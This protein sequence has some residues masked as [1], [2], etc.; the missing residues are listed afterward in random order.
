MAKL[1]ENM[2]E[3]ASEP[4]VFEGLPETG[5]K[6]GPYL[7]ERNGIYY[8]TYPH[9]QNKTERLEYAV[10]DNPMGPLKFTGTIMDES[11]T[12]CWTN[13]QSF[14]EFN[15]QWYLLYHHND[16]SPQFDKNRSIRIDSLFF[17]KDGT[18]QKVTPTLRGVGLTS[19]SQKIELEQYLAI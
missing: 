13:H 3:L 6:E 14:I 7:F 17:N 8:M 15:N 10:G 19:A 9:V 2:L 11:P 5:L 4:Q 1:K 12:G 18:I 16:L